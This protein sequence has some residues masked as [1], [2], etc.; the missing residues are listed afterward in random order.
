MRIAFYA[1]MK[2]PEHPN[3][4]GDRQIAQLL[5]RALDQGG[6]QVHLASQHRSYDGTGDTRAQ[7]AIKREGGRLASRLLDAY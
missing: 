2:S 7:A 3:P 1:P 6:H 5:M 4:S